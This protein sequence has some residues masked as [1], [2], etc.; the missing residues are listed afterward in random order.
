[1]LS[2]HQQRTYCVAPSPLYAGACQHKP[3]LNIGLKSLGYLVNIKSSKNSAKHTR[4]LLE[5]MSYVYVPITVLHVSRYFDLLIGVKQRCAFHESNI[6]C[7]SQIKLEDSCTSAQILHG[8]IMQYAIYIYLR[9]QVR[10]KDV[11]RTILYVM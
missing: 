7:D 5:L 1:M 9:C 6:T 10:C 2:G 3:V 11:G 4:K 8:E